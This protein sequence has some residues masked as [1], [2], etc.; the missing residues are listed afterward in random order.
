MMNSPVKDDLTLMENDED[1]ER[2]DSVNIILS[3]I[4]L[5]SNEAF[6][7]TDPISSESQCCESVDDITRNN[8]H[9][10]PVHL[11]SVN[12]IESKEP[13]PSLDQFLTESVHMET[14]V[15]TDNYSAVNKELPNG[16][17]SEL[18]INHCISEKE[19]DNYETS[20]SCILPSDE[21]ECPIF[22]VYQKVDW[23]CTSPKL[24]ARADV[25]F[26]SSTKFPSNNYLRGCLWSPDGSCILTNSHDNVLRLFNLPSSILSPNIEVSSEPE[27]MRSVLTMYENELIYDYCWYPQMC[28]SDPVSCCLASTSRRNPIR[29]WDAFTGVIRATYIPVNHLGEVVSASSISFSSNGSRLYAGFHRY[30]QVFD[31]CRPGSDSIRRPKLGKKP[32]QGGIISSI[33][34]LNDPNRNI[35]A[36]GSYNG[37]VCI[38]SEPGNLIAQLFSHPTGVTQVTLA[39]TFGRENAAPWYVLAGGRMDS[40]LVVWDA[41]NL[42]D[43][44]TIVYRRIENHQ[45]FQFDLEPLKAKSSM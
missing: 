18:K 9:R 12:N 28:S 10:N 45:K 31:V 14:S 6:K 13:D 17:P 4:R 19:L 24:I 25:E 34:V 8:L 41:R 40:R 33:G 27:E 37:T 20:Y 23:V 32:F 22:D 39:K 1:N 36:T 7:C 15:H 11:L 44:I 2:N 42:V 30:I 5:T 3:G 26:R 16:S 29:L 21:P 38:F 35:Y 43:P